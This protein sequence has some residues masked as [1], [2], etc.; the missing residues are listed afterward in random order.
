M[1]HDIRKLIDAQP[2]VPFTIHLAEGG[3]LRVPT[4]DHVAIAPNGNRVIVFGDDDDY[5][6]ISPLL[7]S[8]VTVNGHG[9][10]SKR[11]S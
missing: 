10:S 3:H 4:F 7:I 6:V 9:A 8:R 5:A 1:T 11:K 2:F